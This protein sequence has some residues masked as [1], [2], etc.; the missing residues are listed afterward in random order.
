MSSLPPQRLID[1]FSSEDQVMLALLQPEGTMLH[2][3]SYHTYYADSPWSQPSGEG[4]GGG[5]QSPLFLLV[6]YK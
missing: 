5:A 1:S 3:V 6:P 4:G 2:V